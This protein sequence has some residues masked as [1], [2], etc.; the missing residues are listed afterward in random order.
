MEF[1][2]ELQ[3]ANVQSIENR[4]KRIEGGVVTTLLD[5]FISL[6]ITWHFGGM[7]DP[8]QPINKE[9][10][11]TN[12]IV[13]VTNRH[14]IHILFSTKSDDVQSCDIRADLHT[15]QMSVTNVSNRTDIE[16]KVPD[17]ERRYRLYRD[18]KNDGFKVGIRIQ[19]FIPGISTIDILK[20]F[21]DADHFIIEGL[22]LVPQNEEQ[23]SYL[24]NLLKINRSYFTQKGLLTLIP[25]YRMKL[26]KPFI[27]YFKSHHMSYSISDN[28]LRYL[29]NN[30][31]CCGDSLAIS[32][33]I[34]TT[35]MIKKYGVKYAYDDMVNELKN[36]DLGSYRCN[37]LFTSNRTNGCIT[38]S[39]FYKERFYKKS[40]PF[41]PYYQHVCQKDLFDN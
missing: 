25:E 16:P 2:K 18:L 23:K 17:I 19:P 37:E 30:R 7:S 4:L 8:F 11:I 9:L 24:L 38:V 14:N 32:S 12:Q 36:R 34:D 41:S 21:S 15:F 5:K 13:D 20:R 3:I 28:D 39:D 35:C 29:G 10:K 40:S 31:C 22:K 1:K 33:Q 26:Y 6:G 27:D